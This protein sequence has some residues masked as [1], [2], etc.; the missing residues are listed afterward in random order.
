M[1]KTQYSLSLG[2]QRPLKIQ[3]FYEQ[4][5]SNSYS[6]YSKEKY[7][8]FMECYCV[9][10]FYIH[11]I[12][13][14]LCNNPVRLFPFYRKGNSDFRFNNVP[15]I[16]KMAEQQMVILVQVGLKPRSLSFQM[17]LNIIDNSHI[18]NFL[19]GQSVFLMVDPPLYKKQLNS[20]LFLRPFL[21]THAFIKIVPRTNYSLTLGINSL[22]I[23]L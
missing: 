9:Q 8:L 4:N 23:M 17:Y 2:F 21:F 22:Q 3:A 14:Y 16:T 15:K 1:Q 10:V 12:P 20:I 7:Q 19:G 6:L 13:S 5:H 11:Y 18:P